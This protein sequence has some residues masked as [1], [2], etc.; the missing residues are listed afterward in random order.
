M[1][2]AIFYR[3][4]R[5][6]IPGAK[7]FYIR[8]DR[9]RPLAD[10]LADLDRQG[11]LRSYRAT[12]LL[13]V[14]RRNRT[15]L[16]VGTYRV[17]AEMSSSQVLDTLEFP[18]HQMLRLPQNFWAARLAGFL[19]RN[20]VCDGTD[21]VL[22]VNDPSAFQNQVSFPLP[23]RSLEGYLL[24][25]TYDLPP[26]IG[27]PAVVER[28]LK[29]FERKV[30]EPLGKP[31]DLQR[32]LTEASLIQLEVARDEERPLVASV[33]EN[34][35]RK[36]MALQID[37]SVNYALGV[38]RPLTFK[39]LR[40]ANGPYNLYRFKGLPPGP[41][42]SPSLKS[43]EAALKPAKTDYLFYVALPDGHSLFAATWKQHQAN[44]AKRKA[45]LAQIAKDRALKG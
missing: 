18:I 44:I 16:P 40:E 20:E 33:I 12:R 19:E 6:A 39:D 34:R 1:S 31:K 7:P 15:R 38:W 23:T 17:G 32:I 43:I 25:D 29:A 5:P 8:L 22:A 36:H 41:I 2:G 11:V 4:T 21:Y 10:V 27:A 24:P 42:C 3:A 45:A 13:G 37:A 14:L 26:L 28:Q 35:L 30:Y 9:V